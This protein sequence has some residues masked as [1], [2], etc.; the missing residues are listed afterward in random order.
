MS[1]DEKQRQVLNFL[2]EEFGA[3][4]GDADVRETLFTSGRLD[5]LNSLQILAFIDQQFSIKLGALDVTIDEFDT[6]ESI[7]DLIEARS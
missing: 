2:N 4:L 3:G 6:V 5:S 1:R 7:V